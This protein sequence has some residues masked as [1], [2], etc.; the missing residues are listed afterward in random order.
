M[1]VSPRS[2]FH[3][4]HGPQNNMQAGQECRGRVSSLLLHTVHTVSPARCVKGEA[5]RRSSCASGGLQS[6]VYGLLQ[7]CSCAVL[8]CSAL[9]DA[10]V[11]AEPCHRGGCSSVVRRDLGSVVHDERSRAGMTNE[12]DRKRHKKTPAL[13]T[14]DKTNATSSCGCSLCFYARN[15]SSAV[16]A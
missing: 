1:F 2:V 14:T 6:T 3:L 4:R 13:S 10:R 9:H 15:P 5:R 11:L 8:C 12:E 16:S 7:S